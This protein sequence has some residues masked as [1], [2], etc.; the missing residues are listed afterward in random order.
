[1]SHTR[2]AWAVRQDD[3]TIIHCHTRETA[4]FIAER[5]HGSTVV[6]HEVHVT[7]WTEPEGA[8]A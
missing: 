2:T 1:M 7:D 5:N 8:P 3:G 4:Y 6:Y